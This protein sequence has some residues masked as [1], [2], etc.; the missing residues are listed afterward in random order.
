MTPSRSVFVGIGSSHGDDQVGWR[1]AQQLASKVGSAIAVRQAAGPAQLL[2]WLDGVERLAICDACCSSDGAAGTLLR[3]S[4]PSAELSSTR[5]FGSHDVTLPAVLELAQQLGRLPPSV[6][7]WGVLIERAEP[8]AAVSPALEAR[9]P[10]IVNQIVGE[11][12]DA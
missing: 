9:L 10:E 2:D 12:S 5:F 4:W 8:G 1:I 6:T 11:L 7:V 3:W